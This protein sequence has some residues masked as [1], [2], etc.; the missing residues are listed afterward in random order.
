MPF[1]PQSDIRA[2]LLVVIM[3][4]KKLVCGVGNNNADYIVRKMEEIGRIDGKRKRKLVWT[5]PFYQVW[6]SMIDRCY[7]IKIQ[8]KYPTYKGCSVVTEWHLFSN[9]KAWMQKQ[10]W[11]GLQLDKDLLFQGNKVYDP[12]ACV[13]VTP[14]VNTFI[15]D[16]R[17][18][19]GD[20]LIG[21]D[22]DKRTGRFRA[23]CNNPFTKKIE[24]LGYFT[25]EQEAHEAWL[26][27]KLEIAHELAAIQTDPRVAKALVDRYS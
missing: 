11:E 8:E 24:H 12:N 16:Q 9:F 3:K 6:K 23:Q 14:M 21:V 18:S 2:F 25:C 4:P 13:F 5:C 7:S 10:K 20:L 19:R 27:R 26:K 1:P 22:L 17:P 15:N